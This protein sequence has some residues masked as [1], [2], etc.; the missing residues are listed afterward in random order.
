MNAFLDFLPALIFI[1]A[2]KL[3]DIYTATAALIAAMFALVLWYRILTPIRLNLRHRMY[4]EAVIEET[5]GIVSVLIGGRK[6]HRIG[7]E[8]GQFFRWRFLAPGMRFSSH[9]YSLSG[10]AG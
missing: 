4:V 9:P 2:W 5:P 3:Y 6:L 7:A 8:A 1:G 10:A